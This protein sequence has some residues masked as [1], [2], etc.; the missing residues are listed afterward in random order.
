[1]EQVCTIK[2]T[3]TDTNVDVKVSGSLFASKVDRINLLCTLAD[4]IGLDE[5]GVISAALIM[6]L[7]M[8]PK[9]QNG[10]S[11]QVADLRKILGRKEDE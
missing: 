4:A 10:T 11:I 3:T 5:E 1:M 7:G 6:K 8:A 9:C 2:I